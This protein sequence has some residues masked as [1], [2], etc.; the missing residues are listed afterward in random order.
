MIEQSKIT[1]VLMGLLVTGFI[2]WASVIYTAW[3]D[4]RE[5]L[6]DI[7]GNVRV[8]NA[9]MDHIRHDLNSHQE[10]PHHKIGGDKHE[11]HRRRLD[12][13]YERYMK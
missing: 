12:V 10:L 4:V 1:N 11:E 13:L 5:L 7:D 8:T 9:K 2:A 3:Q 6:F